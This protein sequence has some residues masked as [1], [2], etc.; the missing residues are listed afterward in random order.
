M[1]QTD[2]RFELVCLD[3]SGCATP[4]EESEIRRF[5]D[6]KAFKLLDKLRTEH[7]LKEVLP[8]SCNTRVSPPSESP[9]CEVPVW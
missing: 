3:G 2:G 9:L 6:D 8:P 1:G 7:E 4:F 5:L